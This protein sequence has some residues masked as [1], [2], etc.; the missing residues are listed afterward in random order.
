MGE[1]TEKFYCCD[2]DDNNNAL[3]AAIIAGNNRRDDTF[4]NGKTQYLGALGEWRAVYNNKTKVKR[5]MSLI[6][7]TTISDDYYWSSTKYFQYSAGGG[8]I[9]KCG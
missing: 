7:G 3:A 8:I 6:G 2:R 9:N 5:A 1:I 4:P